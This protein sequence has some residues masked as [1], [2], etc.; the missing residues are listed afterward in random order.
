[1]LLKSGRQHIVAGFPFLHTRYTRGVGGLGWNRHMGDTASRQDMPLGFPIYKNNPLLPPSR[2]SARRRR[3]CLSP[4]GVLTR[5]AV[6]RR[7][8]LILRRS[9]PWTRSLTWDAVPGS[10]ITLCQA[11]VAS[12]APRPRC[13]RDCMRSGGCA[14]GTSTTTPLLTLIGIGAGGER[15]GPSWRGAAPVSPNII[16]SAP[17]PD[18]APDP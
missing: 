6:R 5:P 8:P 1:M 9:H 10:R 4:V 3:C 2:V 11:G 14:N 16:A 13:G 7:P 17:S 12:Q 15:A 18:L